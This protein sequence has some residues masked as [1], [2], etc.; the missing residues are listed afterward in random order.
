MIKRSTQLAI[1]GV[2]AVFAALA[3]AS[4]ALTQAGSTGGTIGK[5]GKSAAG[6]EEKTPIHHITVNHAKR[7]MRVSASSKSLDLTGQWHWSA[8]CEK[9]GPF[10]GLFN[11]KQSG[12]VFTGTFGGTNFWDNGTLSNGKIS[13]NHISFDREYFGLDHISLTVANTPS[14]MIMQGPHYN[15]GWGNC[16]IL[17]KKN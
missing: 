7:D 17:A 9:G 12:N 14:G 3:S 10:S 4:S 11:L 2:L 8:K 5:Q 15:A 16:E 6:G 13:G 1:A